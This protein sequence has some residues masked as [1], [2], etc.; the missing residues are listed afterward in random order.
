MHRLILVAAL[1]LLSAVGLSACNK[2]DTANTQAAA[3]V[4]LE[5]PTDAKDTKAWQTYLVG[6]VRQN[7]E[8][9]TARKP[10]LYFIPAGEDDDDAFQRTNQLDNVQTTVART[11]LPGNLM[12][13]AGPDSAI[14]ADFVIEAFSDAEKSSF[15][16]VIVL[17][18][19]DEVDSERVAAGLAESGATYRFVA[20]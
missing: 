16:G 12:A 10:Y 17:F 11:V 8:G 15:N 4:A 7:L 5:R 19:G 13:F 9:M 14:T 6:I 18:I 20:M 1:G 2:Q 3:E